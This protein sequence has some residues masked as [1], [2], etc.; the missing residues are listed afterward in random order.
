MSK[1]RS[2]APIDSSTSNAW[3]AIGLRSWWAF[4]H[5]IASDG[6]TIAGVASAN[7]TGSGSM[8]SISDI[9]WPASMP[10]SSLSALGPAFMRTP[11]LLLP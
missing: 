9:A 2:S 5:C 1:A 11:S 7:S 4:S 10:G 8:I 3:R 6:R